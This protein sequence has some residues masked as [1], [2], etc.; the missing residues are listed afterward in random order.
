[1]TEALKADTMPVT[2]AR[3]SRLII[4]INLTVDGETATSGAQCLEDMQDQGGGC[5]LA[6]DRRQGL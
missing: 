6:R 3:A 2:A 4:T 1:M 5:Y